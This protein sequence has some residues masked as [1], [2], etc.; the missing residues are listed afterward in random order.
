MHFA[1]C[2]YVLSLFSELLCPS[3]A[4]LSW[5]LSLNNA[6]NSWTMFSVFLPEA[7]CSIPGSVFRFS[8]NILKKYCVFFFFLSFYSADKFKKGSILDLERKSFYN[9]RINPWPLYYI[10]DKLLIILP[11][12]LNLWLSKHFCY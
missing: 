3:P 9:I 12:V 7:G 5:H 8:N 4:L 1:E 6:S 2:K 11:S 10:Y